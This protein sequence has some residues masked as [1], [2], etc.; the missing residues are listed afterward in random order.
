[1]GFFSSNLRNQY[2]SF[3]LQPWFYGLE[4]KEWGGL[5]KP[6]GN[7]GLPLVIFVEQFLLNYV[8]VSSCLFPP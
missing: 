4:I 2:V 5:T 1:M 7:P 6:E 8:Q 3:F